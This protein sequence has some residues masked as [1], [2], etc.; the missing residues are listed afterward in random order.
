MTN[1]KKTAIK[2]NNPKYTRYSLLQTGTAQTS[3]AMGIVL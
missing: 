1:G 3:R 2:S